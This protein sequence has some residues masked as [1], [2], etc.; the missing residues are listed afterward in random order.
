MM[1]FTTSTE[2]K[3]EGNIENNVVIDITAIN[4][5]LRD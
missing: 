2:R 4:I 3:Q 5:A 1:E